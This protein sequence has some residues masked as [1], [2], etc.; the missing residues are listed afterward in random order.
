MTER[1]PFGND[2]SEP[3]PN[4][5]A[6]DHLRDIPAGDHPEPPSPL[7]SS[8]YAT[9]AANSAERAAYAETAPPVRVENERYTR[10][11]RGAG[12]IALAL[13][14]G[15]IGGYGGTWAFNYFDDGASSFTALDLDPGDSTVPP[16]AIEQVAAG[17][18]PSVVQ[19]NVTGD[20]TAGA[21]TGIILSEDGV[22]LTNEHV[23]R[24][25]EGD[26]RII[27]SFSN[28][29]R[30]RAEI[31]GTDPATDVAVIKAEG[32]SGLNPATLGTSSDIRVGQTVVAF[33][34]PFGLE[35]TVTAG[36]VSAL[37]R[38]INTSDNPDQATIFPAI[39]TDAAINPG[40][41]GGPLVDLSG[42]VIGVNS[43][44]RTDARDSGSIGLGFAIPID[45]ARRIADQLIAG[46]DV[47]HPRIGVTIQNDSTSAG[48]LVVEVVPGSGAD[49]AGIKADDIITGLN[50][51]PVVDGDSLV[52]NVLNYVPG[53]SIT[54]NILRDG[55]QIEVTVTIGSDAS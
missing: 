54:L 49:E 41:S 2:S 21:G 47:V 52:A 43:A 16:G 53:D 6:F 10:R 3:T 31:I 37:N 18:L 46:E 36:I 35:S 22:I 44:I 48:A 4:P 20:S 8:E 13:I 15:A 26:G 33:G 51:A 50:G 28:G 11:R 30:A 42:R 40:N 39:Q 29:E 24:V 14:F 9:D 55:E 27:V 5:A 38:S 19:L 7:S 45:L 34:S 12:L 32:I 17:V 23:V 25:A 1:D